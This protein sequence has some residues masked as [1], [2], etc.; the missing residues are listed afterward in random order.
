MRSFRIAIAVLALFVPRF[1]V[2]AEPPAPA[3]I[4]QT[5]VVAVPLAP[6]PILGSAI[7]P[8]VNSGAINYAT[9]QV[10]LTGSGFELLGQSPSVFFNGNPLTLVSA[11]N[12]QIVAT[13]PAGLFPGTFSVTIKQW[14]GLGSVAFDMTYGATGPQGPAGPPGLNGA[15]GPAGPPGPAGSP[16]PTGP[17]GPEGIMGN[18]GP[19]GPTGPAGPAGGF[20]S[21]SAFFNP[22]A[23]SNI[24]G[25]ALGPAPVAVSEVELP[26]AGTYII[27]GS[28]T[29]I[30]YGEALTA[31]CYFT[32]GAGGGQM[33][34]PT[35][36]SLNGGVSLVDSGGITTLPQSG[37]FTT[38]TPSVALYLF[39][40]LNGSGSSMGE[41]SSAILSAIQVQ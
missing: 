27:S 7:V 35:G 18:P 31:Q 30:N 5:P 33:N 26:K 2:L 6:S 25:V 9:N 12:T 37:F 24:T 28:V 17:A 4:G 40:Q 21:Y 14:L 3:P 16:G 22:V 39:C 29:V 8:V 41:A 11:S 10:T 15:Q 1:S 23:A 32:T 20:P 36:Y 13:L 34:P 19:Q 38:K